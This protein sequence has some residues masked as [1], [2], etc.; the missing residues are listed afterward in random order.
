MSYGKK[1]IESLQQ[2]DFQKNEFADLKDEGFSGRDKQIYEK[3]FDNVTVKLETLDFDKY[4]CVITGIEVKTAEIEITNDLLQSQAKY[5]V[6]KIDYLT[7]SFALIELDEKNGVA[8]I[9]SRTP[10]HVRSLSD[11]HNSW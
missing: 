10:A 9:R 1:I 11:E 4:S 5:I 7:E 2:M 8:Q 3:T 6:D